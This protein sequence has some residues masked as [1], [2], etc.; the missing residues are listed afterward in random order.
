MARCRNFERTL[1]KFP[2][3]SLGLLALIFFILF[4]SIFSFLSSSVSFF[5]QYTS[6]L[7]LWMNDILQ[8]LHLSS[9]T[10]TPSFTFSLQFFVLFFILSFQ[11]RAPQ[12]ALL[13]VYRPVFLKAL[14]YRSNVFHR[15]RM[16]RRVLRVIVS[17]WW[18][19]IFIKSP[20]GS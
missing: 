2:I 13:I 16:T 20:L 15:R 8:F 12:T 17:Y 7:L 11:Y 18:C 1:V 9:S 19:G 5:R 3:F 10:L 6:L 14:N 4:F